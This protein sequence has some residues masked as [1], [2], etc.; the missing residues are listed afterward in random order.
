MDTTWDKRKSLN[1]LVVGFFFL[2]VLPLALYIVTNLHA[3]ERHGRSVVA[4]ATNC[5]D[6]NSPAL[7]MVNPTTH[8]NAD[9][10]FDGS[11]YHVH[12]TSES[13]SPITTFTKDKMKD[14]SQV[15]RYLQNAG[16][17]AIH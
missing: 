11:K 3:V 8:R 9:V 16:Y 14:L 13:G 4:A 10:C 17:E 12:I 6:N 15:F 5:F 7:H 2:V 1:L